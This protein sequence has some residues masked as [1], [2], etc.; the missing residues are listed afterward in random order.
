VSALGDEVEPAIDELLLENED[1]L[2][3]QLGRRVQAIEGSSVLGDYFDFDVSF[4]P[5]GAREAFR[6]LGARIYQRWESE[7]FGLV[8][9]T[10]S[11]DGGDR[12]KLAEA[13]GVG[14]T[15]VAAMIT[16][17]LAST[18]GLAPAIA[19]VI[20]AIVVKR[21]LRPAYEEFCVVWGD[22]LGQA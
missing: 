5:S 13:F 9:G 22:R 15:A 14:G 1:E 19:A 12:K 3:E 18:F 11:G 21:F 2:F 7:A 20:A 8:C 6:R 4:D 10:G 17:G 16:A